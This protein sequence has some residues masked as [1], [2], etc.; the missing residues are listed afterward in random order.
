MLTHA[1]SNTAAADSASM[2][3]ADRIVVPRSSCMGTTMADSASRV[4][5]L[6]R[7]VR[8]WPVLLIG[9]FRAD[10]RLQPGHDGEEVRGQSLAG[11]LGRQFERQPCVDAFYSCEE[12]A[13][14]E[15][16]A[17]ETHRVFP[18]LPRQ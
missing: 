12:T 2:T 3:M 14:V 18:T 4:G 1:I 11:F 5:T 17:Q 13:S 9:L 15:S 16:P 8:R 7:L 6:R 10:A